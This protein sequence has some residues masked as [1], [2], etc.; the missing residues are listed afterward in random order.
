MRSM[1]IVKAARHGGVRVTLP[2]YVP[3]AGI[4]SVR[5]R[6]LSTARAYSG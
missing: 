6:I 4:L 3:S 1:A 5:F 2:Y